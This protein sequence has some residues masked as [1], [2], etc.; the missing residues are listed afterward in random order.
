MDFADLQIFKAVAEEGGITAAARKLH[1][2]QSN[3]TTRIQQLEA[4]LGTRL[5]IREKRRLMLSPAGTLFLDYVTKMLQ[6]SESARDALNGKSPR[7]V[8]KIGTLE[9]TA[10]SRLPALLSRYHQKYPA[11]RVE[12]M[13]APTD[14]LVEV[15]LNRKVEAAF[16]ADC[17]M[18]TQIE[19]IPVFS[20]ELVLIAP[21]THPKI[22]R[23]QDVKADTLI[24]FPNGCAY[25]RRL[26]NWLAGGRIV[27]DRVL[28]LSS[29]HAIVACVASGTGIA[30]VPLSVL[31]TFRAAEDV[32]VY[33]LGPKRVD[34]ITSLIWRKGETSWPL[35]A[36][37]AELEQHPKQ[38]L[39]VVVGS[40]AQLHT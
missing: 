39:A 32:A 25:R 33:P 24:A 3:V 11:V 8:L 16:V 34:A 30:L 4:S 40:K 23:P 15:V 31:Q 19:A 29:Y 38:R 9:S 22:Q 13:T 1:R 36:L 26:Q 27:A 5:F 28:E 14:M 17:V 18:A 6:I 21:R 2:V 7:G 35:K 12:L 37:Q 20:E 10:A